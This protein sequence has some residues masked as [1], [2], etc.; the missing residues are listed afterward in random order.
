M[1]VDQIHSSAFIQGYAELQDQ[2][3]LLYIYAIMLENKKIF[4][5]TTTK[6]MDN[7]Q[8]YLECKMMY[9]FVRKNAPQKTIEI[10]KIN[11]IL[12][13]D[14]H[15]KQYMYQFGIDCVRGGSYSAEI[16]PTYMTQAL[17]DELSVEHQSLYENDV[18][19]KTIIDQYNS[20]DWNEQNVIN[21]KQ[22][23]QNELDKYYEKQ[24]TLS[25]ISYFDKNKELKIEYSILDDME[26]IK[27]LL[28]PHRPSRKD[29]I[30]VETNSF[31]NAAHMSTAFSL[32]PTLTLRLAPE[33]LPVSPTMSFDTYSPQYNG[34]ECEVAEPKHGC[35][36]R[37]ENCSGYEEEWSEPETY[38]HASNLQW[39]TNWLICSKMLQDNGC[40][41]AEKLQ[42]EVLEP[43]LVIIP[44]LHMSKKDRLEKYK[45]IINKLTGVYQ[46]FNELQQD[47][48]YECNTAYEPKLHVKRPDLVLDNFIY[49]TCKR[50]YMEKVIK[51]ADALIDQL[52][53]MLYTIINRI[54]EYIYDISTYPANFEKKIKSTIHYLDICSLSTH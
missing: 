39:I 17:T 14:Y 54:N 24:N 22:I 1:T 4:L 15:V 36:N 52:N 9:D 35:E 20:F 33:Y 23:L 31:D 8:V 41:E 29:K 51:E 19:I 46:I 26:W 11:H 12:D 50:C 49:H 6:V 27:M 10:I 13:V 3:N 25:N 42:R 32:S 2:T 18:M 21:E 38:E 30:P 37:E 45:T 44:P 53:Y 43:E 48:V 28:L 16:L 5:H 47:C 7:P 40:N 34:A